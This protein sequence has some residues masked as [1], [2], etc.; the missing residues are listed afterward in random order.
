M[1]MLGWAI[2]AA[3]WIITAFAGLGVIVSLINTISGYVQYQSPWDANVQIPA[4][5]FWLLLMIGGLI[6]GTL[7]S[8]IVETYRKIDAVHR[9][10]ARQMMTNE[11]KRIEKEEKGTAF[12]ARAAE[13]SS[14]R[15]YAPPRGTRPPQ[16][17]HSFKYVERFRRPAGFENHSDT[18]G[19]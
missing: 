18:V 9:Y 4:L 2:A 3:F 12:A 16:P 15:A 5:T 19:D 13:S 1:Y 6:M 8:L 10:Y 11:I 17:T 14:S 7:T